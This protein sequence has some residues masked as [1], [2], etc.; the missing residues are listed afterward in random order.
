MRELPM[1]TRHDF[2]VVGDR[3]ADPGNVG[4]IVRSAEAAGAQL[5]WL[6]DGSADP[7]GPK[8]VRASAGS[9]FRV[10]VRTGA[11]D[12]FPSSVRRFAT[13]SH[14]GLVYTDADLTQ[15]LALV[16]GNEAHGLG[17][18]VEVDEW[19]TIPHVGSAESLNVAMAAT[20]L[21]FEVAR[22]RR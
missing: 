21:A 12:G 4:T 20:V 17:S 19:L 1:P 9:L 7:F 8:A 18:D 6:T 11:L 16:L 2:V 14:A 22:Q 5:V 15:P 10:A 3:L 13:S